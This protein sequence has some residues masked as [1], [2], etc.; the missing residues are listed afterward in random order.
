MEN[1]KYLS[2]IIVGLLISIS[3]FF[4]GLFIYKGLN[5]FSDKDRIVTVKGLAEK[6][7][8]ATEAYIN[9]I[10]SS[11]GDN[12]QEIISKTNT[13]I[14]NILNYLK[15]KGY[16]ESNIKTEEIS[17]YDGKEYYR[18]DYNLKQ[19]IKIDRYKA[20]RTIKIT[21]N[22]VEKAS[23]MSNGID[24]DLINK[25]LSFNINCDY[26]FPELNSIKPALI[27]ESTKNARLSGEQFA[28]DSKSKLGKIKTASQGQISIV[29]TYYDD[30]QTSLAPKEPYLQK[31]RVVSTI[32]FFLED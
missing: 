17:I 26:K 32:V 6:E 14:D 4:L 3:L 1:K 18:Y 29:G 16:K 15:E 24:L 23:I 12:P 9:I 25:N 11:S 7:I 13:D 8:K 5:S 30:E 21:T 28:N 27:A 10:V 19:K 22:D 31:A 2:I 20:R